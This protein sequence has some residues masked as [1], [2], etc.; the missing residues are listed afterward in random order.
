[1]SAIIKKVSSYLTASKWLET[2]SL[3]KSYFCHDRERRTIFR[4]LV[5]KK[6]KTNRCVF[7]ARKSMRKDVLFEHYSYEKKIWK[8][9]QN[10]MLVRQACLQSFKIIQHLFPSVRES[11]WANHLKIT[12]IPDENCTLKSSKIIKIIIN[13]I[14][15]G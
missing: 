9:S 3:E 4:T 11:Q 5:K 13:T 14:R 1:M 15:K 6:L 7:S 8:N 2:I 10:L 12:I